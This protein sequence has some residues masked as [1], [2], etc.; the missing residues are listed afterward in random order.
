MRVSIPTIS[1]DPLVTKAF[2]QVSKTEA[3]SR[4]VSF[5]EPGNVAVLTGAGISV[6]SG[7][8]AYRGQNGRYLNPNYHPI[9]FH[10]LADPTPKG[11]RFRQRY[12]ARSYLGWPAI[13]EAKPSTSHYAIGALQYSNLVHK[14]ITQ[15]VDGLHGKA[16]PITWGAYEKQRRILELHGRLRTVSCT[17]G[18]SQSR[19]VFQERISS[20][21]PSWRKYVD[22][23]ARTGSEPRTNPD[24]DVELRGRY[25]TDFVV[26]NCE[27]CLLEGVNADE[28]SI[29]KPDVIFFGESI[30]SAV[31]DRSFRDLECCDKLLVIGTTL[32]TYSAFRIV[33]HALEVGKPVMMLNI[34]P[35]R[36]DK[37]ERI[38]KIEMKSGAVLTDVCSLVLGPKAH[39]DP[40]LR[41]L[42]MS[43]VVQPPIDDTADNDTGG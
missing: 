4:L 6:D 21:N 1:L 18:H 43:G 27:L 22:E 39:H 5:I 24:G 29:I 9:F 19:A 40:E 7:I 23:L 31:K 16:I 34:G 42:M 25:F 3:V 14:L 20:L 28:A 36:A 10:E 11:H 35:T 12:W 41:R 8:R 2:P 37:F 30:S 13:K 38:E 17:R 32:A 26:P 15:N 33:K